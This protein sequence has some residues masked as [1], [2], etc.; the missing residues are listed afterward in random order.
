MKTVLQH[1]YFYRPNLTEDHSDFPGFASLQAYWNM[2]EILAVSDFQ[3]AF[4]SN[5]AV[6]TGNPDA[7]VGYR[8]FDGATQFATAPDAAALSTG[9]I[10]FTIAG[11]LWPDDFAGLV[12]GPTKLNAS[13]AGEWDIYIA[14]GSGIPHVRIW[15]GGSTI[16]DVA[17]GTALT[18]DAWNF[19]VVQHNATADTLRISVNGGAF[20]SDAT[21]G[22]APADTAVPLTFATLNGHSANFF[23]GR[24]RMWG[25]WKAI[26]TD[27]EIA[28]LYNSGNGL[29]F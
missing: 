23:K 13:V 9:N 7:P 19:V 12:F 29:A 16:V 14:A 3:D 2:D 10:D 11:W 24:M 18:E 20:A 27:P 8:G 6:Q 17:S 28:A 21:G 25:F 22:A 1:H 4:G 5:T 26:L 15:N